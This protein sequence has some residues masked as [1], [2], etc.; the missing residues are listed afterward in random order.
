MERRL[1]NGLLSGYAII[2][3]ENDILLEQQEHFEQT[4]PQLGI[5]KKNIEKDISIY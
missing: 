2:D 5:T 3:D 1:T 4:N